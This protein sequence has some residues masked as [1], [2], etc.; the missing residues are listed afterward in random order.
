MRPERGGVRGCWQ[1]GRSSDQKIGPRR[2]RRTRR[3]HE[4][5]ARAD[6]VDVQLCCRTVHKIG[7]LIHGEHG[8]HR[9][10]TNSWRALSSPTFRGC[11]NAAIWE[12]KFF[13]IALLRVLRV[14]RGSV[15]SSSPHGLRLTCAHSV[16][17]MPYRRM[18]PSASATPQS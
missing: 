15:F 5:M 17:L 3:E 11:R 12:G 13:F 16:E 9:E 14:L 8:E 18:N 1:A 2:T 6:V 7:R 10:S 4:F